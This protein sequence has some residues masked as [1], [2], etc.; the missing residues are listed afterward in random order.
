VHYHTLCRLGA[1]LALLAACAA[2]RPAG[3]GVSLDLGVADKLDGKYGS[4]V[5]VGQGE[6]VYFQMTD[7]SNFKVPLVCVCEIP[8]LKWQGKEVLLPGKQS[9]MMFA[10]TCPE[11]GTFKLTACMTYVNPTNGHLTEE[12]DT[13]TIEVQ[14]A[15]DPGLQLDPGLQPVDT[16][17]GGGQ[18]QTGG[19]QQ[20]G[21][22]QQTGGQQQSGGNQQGG[23][24]GGQQQTGGQQQSGGQQQTG[25][26]QGGMGG[27]QG[28]LPDNLFSL[29]GLGGGGDGNGNG[30]KDD[31]GSKGHGKKDDS[32]SKGHGKKG[33][34]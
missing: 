15:D 5:E 8:M 12:E 14:P 21:G 20:S 33:K 6:K 22:Q 27:Q 32:G 10:A 25:S 28:G 1:A 3:A 26:Q 7:Q 19:Q 30:K 9:G 34:D 29:L 4:K 13:V 11:E 23:K 18:Q 31:S 2:A 16:G 17:K 24:G